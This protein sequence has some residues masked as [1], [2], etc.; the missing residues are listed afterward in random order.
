MF[1]VSL[2]LTF[3]GGSVVRWLSHGIYVLPI[4][5]FCQ[6][7]SPYIPNGAM[8]LTHWNAGPGV[9]FCLFCSGWTVFY[10]VF[11]YS[12]FFLYIYVVLLFV[13]LSCYVYKYDLYLR[14]SLPCSLVYSIIMHGTWKT[15][16]SLHVVSIWYCEQLFINGG[17]HY[18]T[19]LHHTV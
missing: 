11:L 4:G 5:C 2:F 12:G 16:F 18:V 14:W 3:S 13:F 9:L 6:F 10:K 8:S 1:A 19:H 15:H 7:W 17:H